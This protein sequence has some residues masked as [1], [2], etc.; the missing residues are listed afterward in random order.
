M[1][2]SIWLINKTVDVE[3]ETLQDLRNIIFL[4]QLKNTIFCSLILN[5][6]FEIICLKNTGRNFLKLLFFNYLLDKSICDIWNM[7]KK[8]KIIVVAVYQSEV[9]TDW[10]FVFTS[11]LDS[12]IMVLDNLELQRKWPRVVLKC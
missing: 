8:G 6:I 5:N 11:V 2:V 3:P 12:V 1:K 4:F 9:T 7:Q 10:T